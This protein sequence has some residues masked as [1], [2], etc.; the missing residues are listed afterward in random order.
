VTALYQY[1]GSAW[2]NSQL[3]VDALSD[4][5]VSTAKLAENAVT[6]AKLANGSVGSSQ[7]AAAVTQSISDAQS[8]AAAAQGTA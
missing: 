8:A 2:V 5:A 3:G 4:G 6:S 7:L 1:S